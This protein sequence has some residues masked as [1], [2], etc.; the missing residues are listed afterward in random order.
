MERQAVEFHDST[1]KVIRWSGADAVL[2]MRV[3]I[4][5]SVGRPGWDVGR[6]WYQEAEV[7]VAGAKIQQQ[8]VGGCLS[9]FDGSVRVDGELFDNLIPLPCDMTG[10]VEIAFSGQEGALAATGTAIRF[11]LKGEP[12]RVEAFRP[13]PT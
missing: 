10:K 13:L 6:G 3:F 1:V 8:P 4:H 11:A 5:S 9:I 7:T 12:G 2:E